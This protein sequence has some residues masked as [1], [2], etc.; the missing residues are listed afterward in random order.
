MAK[1]NRH[2]RS[3]IL[4]IQK[5]FPW[6]QV[7]TGAEIGVWKGHNSVLL[8]EAIP[9]L[10]LYC[11]DPWESGGDHVTMPTTTPEVFAEAREEFQQLTSKFEDRC[12]SI[13]NTSF[14]A[15][16]QIADGSLDFVF[17]DGDHTYTSAKQDLDLWYPKVRHGGVVS[18]HDYRWIG[19]GIKTPEVKRA[20]DEFVDSLCCI[21]QEV[22]GDVWY[23]IK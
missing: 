23:F 8:L 1:H 4:L 17:I 6:Q 5:F 9:T 11:V 21:I 19:A 13:P 7:V 14:V 18:G 15:S 22:S 12:I 3:L 10:K 20:V 2:S 16:Q